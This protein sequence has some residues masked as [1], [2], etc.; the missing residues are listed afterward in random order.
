MPKSKPSRGT[1]IPQKIFV[2]P[3]WL[4]SMN[5]TGK[6]IGKN[7]RPSD[8]GKMN[9]HKTHTSPVVRTRENSGATA[10]PRVRAANTKIWHATKNLV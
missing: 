2:P 1:V 10:P 5:M 9:K 7:T 6:R 4:V 3:N 8:L